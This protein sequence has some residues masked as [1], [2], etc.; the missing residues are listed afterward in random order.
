MK[1]ILFLVIS[2]LALHNG[3]GAPRTAVYKFVRCI[4]KADQANCVTQQSPEMA[5]SPDLPAKLPASTAQYLKAEPEEGESPPKG[6]EVELKMEEGETPWMSEQEDVSVQTED[7]SGSFEGSAAESTFMAD[8]AFVPAE[9]ET[10]SG[11]SR[12]EEDDELY[13]VGVARGM[14]RLFPGRSLV[15]EAKPAEQELREDH[16]LQL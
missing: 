15:G 6:D 4:P 7:G 3:R 10:G 9:S 16:L 13:K 11:E 2:C 12:T 8:W 5:W 14:M 1:L